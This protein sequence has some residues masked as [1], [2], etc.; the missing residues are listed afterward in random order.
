[1]AWFYPSVVWFAHTFSSSVSYLYLTE[2]QMT[3]KSRSAARVA[4]CGLAWQLKFH[5]EAEASPTVGQIFLQRA[6]A[7]ILT[8]F[9]CSQS[10]ASLIKKGAA[11]ITVGALNMLEDTINFVSGHPVMKHV[12]DDTRQFYQSL[13][14][15]NAS[16]ENLSSDELA[17]DCLRAV[18]TLA[19]T[20]THG[21]AHALDHLIAPAEPSQGSHLNSK[22]FQGLR[23]LRSLGHED[24]SYF[25]NA[26]I[27]EKYCRYGLES[28]RLNHWDPSLRGLVSNLGPE[29]QGTD[30][31]LCLISPSLPL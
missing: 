12:H 6:V 15:L 9:E 13:R 29:I 10:I 21:A 2:S 31:S 26:D 27:R 30:V 16:Q 23:D 5:I 3:F 11:V 1:L 18:A 24:P 14:E 17:A 7:H 4:A 8:A 22:T 25:Q 19:Y 28:T 20:M